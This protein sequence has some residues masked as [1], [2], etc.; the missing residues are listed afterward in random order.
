MSETAVSMEICG[1]DRIPEEI[2]NNPDNR[3]KI[4]IK[5]GRIYL[6][7]GNTVVSCP[8]CPAGR[9]ITYSLLVSC[10]QKTSGMS[11]KEAVFSR[12]LLDAGFLPDQDTFRKNRIDPDAMRRVVVFRSYASL[13]KDLASFFIDIVPME[14]GDI[15]IPV[16]FH[17]VAFIK[18]MKIQ[19]EDELKEFTEAVIGTMES[20]GITGVNAG[21]GDETS[22]PAGLRD[23]FQQGNDAL[24]TGRKYHSRDHVFLYSGQIL[25]RI[26]DSIPGK[27][28][29]EMTEKLFGNGSRTGGLSDE[30]LETVR[31]FFQNDLNLTAAS[32]QLFIHRNTLNYRLDKIRKETGLDLRSFEDAVVFR[33]ISGFMP[34]R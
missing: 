5:D 12:I 20:E 4:C 6:S 25:E 15:V 10:G 17:T 22:D 7:L 19:T 21:I 13:E 28:R 14:T 16:D 32:R 27:T 8:D 1:P 11:G 18:E 2:R 30:M 23:S 34:D 29:T 31:V 26:L 9:E 24:S 3:Q 33:I